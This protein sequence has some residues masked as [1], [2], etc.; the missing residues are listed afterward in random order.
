[1]SVVE[2][3]ESGETFYVNITPTWEAAVRIYLMVLD[4]P[5]ADPKNRRDAQ[6]EI[7]RLARAYDANSR[8][9]EEKRGQECAG[10]KD[11]SEMAALGWDDYYCGKH[12]KMQGV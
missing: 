3:V 11:A 8:A 9:V 10:C 6:E 2:N 4:N 5:N 12:G 7:L 1:M